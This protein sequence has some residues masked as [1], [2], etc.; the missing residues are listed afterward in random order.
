MEEVKKVETPVFYIEYE[1]KDITTYITPFVISVTYTDNFNKSDEIQIELEDSQHLW[2]SKWYPQKGD[3]I[4]LLIGYEGEK[5]LP[6]GS[7]EIDEVELRG[8]PDT[9]TIKALSANI[10][11]TTRQINTKAYENTTLRQIVK[12]IAATHGYKVVGNIEDIRIERITQKQ[13]KDMEFL[14]KL[15]ERYG[16]I[17]K[18]TDDQLVFY[19]IDELEK[20]DTVYVVKRTDIIDFEFRDK[21]YELYKACQISYFDPKTKRTVTYTVSDSSI[22]KGDTLKINERVENKQQAILKAQQMLKNKNRM[23]TEGKITLT[24]NPKLVAGNNI[25]LEGFYI[26]DGVY[27]ITTATHT[28]S[29]HEGYKTYIEVIKNGAVCKSGSGGR[30]KSNG[31]SGDRR[32]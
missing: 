29:K 20:R 4:K 25:Q 6:C 22:T 30:S 19:K 24:G 13:E 5:L 16:Y 31:K 15:A 23:Q 1:Q 8:P 12:Q 27:Q 28:I 17:V 21:T 3:K 18:I 11:K 26:F 9:V 14:L 7:F 2:K 10:K 32:C